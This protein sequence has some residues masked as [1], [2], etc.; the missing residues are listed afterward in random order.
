MSAVFYTIKKLLR[1][2]GLRVHSVCNQ[3]LLP[4]H[5]AAI[6]KLERTFKIRSTFPGELPLDANLV[7]TVKFVMP[8]TSMTAWDK[9]L[10]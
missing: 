7:Q 5:C 9:N 1:N 8:G 4:R 2:L 6:R 10:F 3:S